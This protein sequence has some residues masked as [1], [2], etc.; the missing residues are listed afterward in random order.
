MKVS[1]TLNYAEF[2]EAN[3]YRLAS[4]NRPLRY[5][6]LRRVRGE[7]A[8]RFRISSSTRRR[9]RKVIKFLQTSCFLQALLSCYTLA[10]SQVKYN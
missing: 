9:T 4:K 2:L 10:E 3:Q 5:R 6:G 1:F 8:A 7:M